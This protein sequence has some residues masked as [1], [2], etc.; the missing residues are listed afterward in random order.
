MGYMSRN[1][2]RPA[3][4]ASKGGHITIINQPAI[5]TFLE[6]CSLPPRCGE[7]EMLPVNLVDV[8]IPEKNPIEIIIAIDGGYGE[9]V[10]QKEFP[11]STITFFN[12][13]ALMF[14]VSDLENL[15]TVPFIDPTDI[16]RLKN[17]QR[18]PFVLPIKNISLGGNTLTNSVRL[19]LFEFFSQSQDGEKPFI[20]AL[21]W[22]I[23][24]Q[25]KG[26]KL[27]T[28][29]NLASCPSCEARNIEIKDS[30][31][32]QFN[33]PDC[34]K[35]IY[36]TDIFRLHEVIDD[37]QG[38][39]GVVG[40]TMG[41]LEQILMVHLIKT[42]WDMKPEL[43]KSILFI[44]DGPLA[45]FGQ[46]ANIHKPMRELVA[47]LAQKGGETPYIN[48][49]G[50]EKSGAF[51]DHAHDVKSK[52]GPGQ[53]LILDNDYIYKYIIPG[54]ADPGS[55]YGRTTYYGNKVIYRTGEDKLYVLTL[56]TTRLT[57]SPSWAD[58]PNFDTILANVARLKCDMYDDA[59][60]PVALVN[61][62][63]SLSQHPSMVLL[64]QF[65]KKQMG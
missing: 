9:A 49:V 3:E 24:Q 1:N 26:G 31:G 51:V 64:E 47:F 56:P 57:G 35:R 8:Q 17:I 18:F 52:L 30:M 34:G 54:T 41:L 22:L 40:Y 19:A 33:C 4:Y 7:V 60:I 32:D 6:R 29:W 45:F 58:F 23:F 46:T 37:E 42:I 55:P 61:K 65:A 50:I 53:T 59:L 12:V 13:G 38:A 62:L 2:R 11:S 10:V 16:A 20:E 5:N 25:Y 27:K 14:R 36:L 44:K 63:V 48:M 21:R 15:K 28:T 39:G 43:L